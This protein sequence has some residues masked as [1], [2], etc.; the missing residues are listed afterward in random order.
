MFKVKVS[1]QSI[2][3][4]K[5]MDESL[6]AMLIAW[7][8]KNLSQTI[9]PRIFGKSMFKKDNRFWQYRLGD[10]RLLAIIYDDSRLIVLTDINYNDSL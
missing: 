2:D 9:N 8:R 4:F 5:G 3:K 1:K 6:S 10:F 7:I